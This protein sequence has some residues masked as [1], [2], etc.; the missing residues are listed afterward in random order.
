MP[1]DWEPVIGLEVHAELLTKSKMF[2]SCAV[3]ADD[4]AV[5]PN[6][7]VCPVCMALPGSLPVINARAVEHTLRAGL[8]LNCTIGEFNIFARKNYFYPDLPKGYQISQ[9]E[10]PLCKQGW[11]EIEL[12]EVTKRIGITRVHLEEDTGKL[13]HAGDASLVDLNRAGV[14][15]MEIVSEPD[16]RSVDE[17]KAYATK[18]RA[19]LRYL[20]VSSGDMERGV[21]RFEANVSIR[22]KGSSKLFTRTEIKNLNSFRALAR[23]TEYEI[24]RQIRVVE[25]GGQVVQ[26][27]LG[28]NEMRGETYPQRSKEYADDYRYFPEPDLL[29]LQVSR[30]EVERIRATLPELP[31]AKRDRFMAQ[32]GLS[33]YDATLLAA[34][35]AVADYY[36]TCIANLQPPALRASDLRLPAAKAVAN[37]MT[38]ELFRLMNETGTD[39]EGVKVKPDDLVSLIELVDKG[40]V[41]QNTAKLVFADM[42]AM[43]ESPAA[44]IERKGLMQISDANALAA[45]V[46][47]VLDENP[48]QVAEYLGGKEQLFKWLLGQVMRA[49]RG[50]A[51]PPATTTVLRAALER[52]RQPGSD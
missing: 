1:H 12:G 8:A 21:M 35:R 38:G 34:E 2:C 7:H 30:E 25:S 43:G 22:P 41:N 50:Q 36:E 31:D 26:E 15:L 37:W 23:A 28:W 13:I 17:V 47:R 29:P 5:Q 18:L 32:Y 39:I 40:K 11:L 3:I 20:G 42:F 52:R 9:Y 24:A 19:M 10:Y 33:Q 48:K 45:I 51:N 49:A 6:T 44:I 14:P 4:S 46:E 16:M 27:T